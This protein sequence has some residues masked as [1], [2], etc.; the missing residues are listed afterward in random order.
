MKTFNEFINESNVVINDSK[1]KV[2]VN[3]DNRG[4]YI[5]FIPYSSTLTKMST[6]TMVEKIT[7]EFEKKMPILGDC[8]WFESGIAKN[9]PAGLIF[10]IDAYALADSISNTLK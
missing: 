5:Q 1:F 9:S 6:N 7:K 3:T 8:I 4:T 2:S 10:R